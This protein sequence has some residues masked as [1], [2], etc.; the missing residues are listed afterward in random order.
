[1]PI[2]QNTK[3]IIK[4]SVI[5]GISNVANKIVSVVLLP[6]ITRFLSIA[7]VGIFAL[8]EMLELTLYNIFNMGM[9]NAI[10]KNF[11]ENSDDNSKIIAS[12][13]WFRIILNAIFTCILLIIAGGILEFLDIDN[14][15]LPLINL[16]I[17]NVFLLVISNFFLPIWRYYNNR[18]IFSLVSFIRLLGT[19]SISI[20]LIIIKDLGLWGILYA[21]IGVNAVI[22]IATIIFVLK[23]YFN[24]LSFD[25]FIKLQKYGI[26]FILLSLI[27]PVLNTS[28]R[29]FIND[30]LNL[31]DVAIFSISVKIGMITNMLIVTPMQLAWQPLMYKIGRARENNSYY[32][33]FS[34]YYTLLGAFVVICLSVFSPLLIKLFATDA[35]ISSIKFIPFIAIAFMVEGYRHFFLSGIALKDKIGILS[36][37]SIS[38]IITN[39]LL[40]YYLIRVYGVWGAVASLIGSYTLLAAMIYY[41]SKKDFPIFWALWRKSSILSIMLILIIINHMLFF[42]LSEFS[43][44]SFSIPII[45]IVLTYLLGLVGQKEINGVKEM[46][47]LLLN[48]K[49]DRK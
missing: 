35:Y 16:T 24:N 30:F 14:K 26:H 31:S 23:N 49:A 7:E 9:G 28:N 40:N 47:N 5:Y 38:I 18:Y 29:I 27:T 43:L 2:R 19:I 11:K 25:L 37:I 41:Y 12:A 36:L 48:P 39:L 10:Y 17:L 6:V 33:D 4:D 1:M 34:H 13:F 20:Y 3:I 45:F 44:W 21:K 22:S 8:L 32:T 42:N 46:F 15:Y